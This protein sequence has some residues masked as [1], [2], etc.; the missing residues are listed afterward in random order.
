MH[1]PDPSCSQGIPGPKRRGVPPPE[2]PGPAFMSAE[3]IWRGPD[4]PGLDQESQELLFS[5]IPY[6][7]MHSQCPLP[8]E[9]LYP[10]CSSTSLETISALGRSWGS[11]EKSA[12]LEVTEELVL[13][14]V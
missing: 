5:H 3:I 7:H 6:S 2:S 10:Q 1:T 14:D 9:P 8:K 12:M 4:Q 13:R 11:L